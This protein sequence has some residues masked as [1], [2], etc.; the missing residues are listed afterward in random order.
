M[1]ES[2]ITSCLCCPLPRSWSVAHDTHEGLYST[3]LSDVT[4]VVKSEDRGNS[5]YDGTGVIP[6]SIVILAWNAWEHTEACLHSLRPTLRAGDQVIVVDNGSEDGTKD[7]L[8]AFDWVEVRTNA[9]NRGFAGGCNQGAELATNDV[10]VFL[11]NDTILAQGWLD[12]L[13]APFADETVGAAGPRSDNVSGYQ[14]ILGVPLPSVDRSGFDAFA[15]QRRA[16]FTGQ[17]T[18]TERLVG[19]CLAVRTEA[20]RTVQGF[21]ERYEVGGYEDDDLCRKLMAEGHRLVVAE[22]SYLHHHAHAT[23]DANEVDWAEQELENKKR[24][25]AKWGTSDAPLLTACLIMKNEEEMLADCLASLK[26]A[27]DEIVIYDTGSTDRSV[28]I[29]RAAGAT[30]VE[31]VWENNF[32]TARNAALDM[33]HGTWVLSID[34]DERLVGDP[35]QIRAQ[36]TGTEEVIERLLVSIEN[37]ESNTSRIAH[38]HPRIFRRTACRWHLRIHEQPLAADDPA[39]PQGTG[40]LLGA[41]LIHLGYL[42][43]V[44]QARDKGE[45]NLALAKAAL[46]DEESDHYRMSALLNYCRALDSVGRGVE[47]I[48]GLLQVERDH[49]LDSAKRTALTTLLRTLINEKRFAEAHDAVDRLRAISDNPLAADLAAARV[50]LA[51]GQYEEGLRML[52]RIPAG[53]RDD[54]G[55]QISRQVLAIMQ[56]EALYALGRH[57]EGADLI[58]DSVR[59]DG[60]LDS[61]LGE[62]LRWLSKGGRGAADLAAVV[63]PDDLLGLMG[64]VLTL[65]LDVA[66][67][68]ATAICD[69]FPDRL[70]LLAAASRFAPHLSVV[71]ALPWSVRLRQRGLGDHCPLVLMA[72]NS[73]L[74]AAVRLR[75]AAAA[76]GVFG[77]DDRIERAGRASLDAAP[78]EARADLVAEVSRMAPPLAECLARAVVSETVAAIGALSDTVFGSMN[79]GGSAPS[80]VA[81]G[82]APPG[83]GPAVAPSAPVTPTRTIRSIEPDTSKQFVVSDQVRRGGL[84]IVGAF[85]GSTVEGDLARRLATALRGQG[86][87]ISTASYLRDKRDRRVAWE[88]PDAGDHPYDT[89]LLVIRPE[90]M[91]DLVE[92]EGL[93]FL[94]DRYVV[95][96]WAWEYDQPASWMADMSTIVHEVWVPNRT[97]LSVVT[98]FVGAKGFVA[99]LP[100]GPTP[101]REVRRPDAPFTFVASVDFQADGRRQDAVAAVAAYCDAFSPDDGTRLVVDVRH[102]GRFPLGFAQVVDAVGDRADIEIA[103]TSDAEP[104]WSDRLLA[105]ADAYISLHHADSAL[106]CVTKAMAWKV[107]VV[108][109]ETRVTKDLPGTAAAFLVPATLEEADPDDKTLPSGPC[110]YVADHDQAVQ[111]L[112]RVRQDELAR[113]KR[114]HRAAQLAERRFADRQI[115]RMVRE[116]LSAIA[117]SRYGSA[118]APQAKGSRL[119]AV[120]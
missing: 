112:R 74:D 111:Q 78:S 107:P 1:S 118:K 8:R 93:G 114:I 108:V 76:A 105:S 14:R 83:A 90:H 9:V 30:V 17:T 35:T 61:D 21:D 100:A 62:L 106:H 10:V 23:F 67:E 2:S 34:A 58:L 45:R 3:L 115:G 104:Q 79:F 64:R 11:N 36:L 68:L 24:F 38:M 19:F 113:T 86:V 29:A 46:D 55:G 71:Q 75:A 7:G 109:T 43:E 57:A 99:P 81:T 39:R 59:S 52:E 117:I 47:G 91:L 110:W 48:E 33:A 116:R 72:E 15:S 56:G 103:T 84:N 26:G 16:E 37:L 95:G 6:A 18:P 69:R 97:A 70:E 102:S 80:P 4:S 88:H 28:E 49:P 42:T 92:D 25:Q 89:T 20:F 119:A 27:V 12:E 65:P 66:D 77:L 60:I 51:E 50:A 94:A 120:R 73:Q 40:Q 22:G 87:R 5:T 96:L 44:F 82:E 85:E 98:P 53:G 63:E 32:S 54:D 13:T 101:E 41:K 31:G